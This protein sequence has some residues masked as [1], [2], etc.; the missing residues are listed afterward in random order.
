MGFEPFIKLK[1]KTLLLPQENIDTDQIIPAR[2]LTTTTRT[3]LGEKLFYD[4]R[5][6]ESGKEKDNVLNSDTAKTCKILVVGHNFGC[7]SSREH[8]P[9]ALYD[10]GFRAVISSE[11]ADIFYANALKNGL[12]P[13]IAPK[14]AHDWLLQNKGVEIEINLENCQLVFPANGGTHKFG[15]D[16]FSRECL[17]NGQDELDYLVSL[18]A[19]INKYEKALS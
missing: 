18:N 14:Q 17:L 11:I 8:A 13:I 16:P 6:D 10:Y 5:Y 3:G 19:E 9:W 7:G 4:W 2:F 12:L 1:S 15:I